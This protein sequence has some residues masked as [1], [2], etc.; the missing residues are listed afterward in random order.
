MLA[1]IAEPEERRSWAV[2]FGPYAMV[3]PM[4]GD[5]TFYERIGRSAGT[6]V[7][8]EGCSTYEWPIEPLFGAPAP[9]GE[10]G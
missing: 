4:A 5:M 8:F 10:P 3:Y 2:I 6:A 1:E 7:T 9:A